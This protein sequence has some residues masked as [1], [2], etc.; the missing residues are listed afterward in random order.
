MRV[1]EESHAMYTLSI[2]IN[3]LPSASIMVCLV[4]SF[5]LF[6]MG[7]VR[8]LRTVVDNVVYEADD[9]D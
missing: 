6:D 5:N 3:M 2:S 9:E 8:S 7:M 1:D 4:T